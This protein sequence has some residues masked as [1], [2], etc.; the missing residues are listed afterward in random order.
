MVGALLRELAR[1]TDI[2]ARYGGEE[3]VISMPETTLDGASILCERVRQE[4]ES[5]L[6]LTASIG[7]ASTEHD[8]ITDDLLHA[9]D[10]ALDQSKKRRSQLGIC[11][12]F[13]W[14]PCRATGGVA[15][16]LSRIM[17]PTRRKRC[18]RI[19]RHRVFLQSRPPQM[20]SRHRVDRPRLGQDL[21]LPFGR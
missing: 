16:C 3:F 6:D 7:T 18:S 9:A 14:L 15:C 21:V 17:M 1:E 20:T 5:E 19:R 8:G 4:I 13:R 11:K 10:R 2:V 12:R